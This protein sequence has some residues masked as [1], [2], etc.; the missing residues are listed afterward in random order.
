MVDSPGIYLPRKIRTTREAVRSL[1]P[2]TRRFIIALIVEGDIL[3]E[4][5]EPAV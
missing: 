3:L 5:A 2:F 4:E 1:D